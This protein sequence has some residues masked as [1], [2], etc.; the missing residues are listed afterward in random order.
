MQGICRKVVDGKV[1]YVLVKG[2]TG[3]KFW[4]TLE[5]YVDQD[6]VPHVSTLPVCGDGNA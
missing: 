2:P 6:I 3:D 1:K 4:M 5:Q